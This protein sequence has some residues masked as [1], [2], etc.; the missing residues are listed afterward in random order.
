MINRSGHA[1]CRC[2]GYGFFSE[3]IRML[4]ER[5][6]IVSE[7]HKKKCR[8][9]NQRPKSSSIITFRTPFSTKRFVKMKVIKVRGNDTMRTKSRE[10]ETKR[11]LPRKERERECENARS[12]G[13]YKLK[14][15]NVICLDP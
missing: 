10:A 9:K 13:E 12:D 8:I 14:K 2:S 3:N 15:G 1:P 11:N 5:R 4:M 7:S 6:M